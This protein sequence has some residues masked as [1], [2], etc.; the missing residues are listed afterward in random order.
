M[1]IQVCIVV[2]QGIQAPNKIFLFKLCMYFRYQIGK[3]KMF[4]GDYIQFTQKVILGTLWN[5]ISVWIVM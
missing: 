3:I 2:L 4:C 5:F 1:F